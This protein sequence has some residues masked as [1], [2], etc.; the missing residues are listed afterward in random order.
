MGLTYLHLA[1]ALGMSA[2][3]AEY[4]IA[5]SMTITHIVT[6][7]ASFGSLIAMMYMQPGI[8]KYIVFAIFAIALGQMLGPLVEHLEE[9]GLLRQVLLMVAGIFA[10]MTALAFYD[11]GSF[12]GFGPYLF[13][14]LIGLIV[15]QIIGGVLGLTGTVDAA[16]FRN[17]N[18]VFAWAGA[19]LFTVY[20]AY[21]TQRM[22]ERAAIASK[23]P[24]Y[25][26]ASLKLY[27]DV[28]NLFTDIGVIRS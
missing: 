22:K 17:M 10:G 15:M 18:Q 20:I 1:A 14:G 13:A 16:T 12:L 8:P 5:S 27:L 19:V 28:I 23:N 11:T 2:I 7:V 6:M 25:I 3:S 9:K 4:P 24:D 26:A 21:D